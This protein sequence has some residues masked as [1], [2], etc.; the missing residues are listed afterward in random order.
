MP[1]EIVRLDATQLAQSGGVLARA[2]Q[3]DPLM[4]HYLPEPRRREQVLPGLMLSSL[5]Y[6]HFYGELWTTR[7]LEGV[8]CWL[9]PG[10]TEMTLWGLLRAGLGTVSP[11][12]GLKALWAIRRI[13]PLVDRIHKAAMPAP[14]WYLM[15]LGVDPA[16]QGQ[17]IGARLVT[18]MLERAHA[19]GLSCYLET[20]TEQNVNF[21][22]KLGFEVVRE[23]DLTRTGLHLWA[24]CAP[25]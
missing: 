5:R 12:I 4:V 19:A 22:R 17:G 3:E 10:R 13:E 7:A 25:V 21:Y 15:V 8:A 6:C 11:L 16:A 2:F 18:S 24:M 20:M 14:H 1:A 23:A 9:P